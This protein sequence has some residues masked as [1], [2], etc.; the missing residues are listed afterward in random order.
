VIYLALTARL[1]RDDSRPAV[2]GLYKY[3]LLYLA[4][5][6]VVIMVDGTIG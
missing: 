3:S 1:F 4:L 6:F 2:L 5:L